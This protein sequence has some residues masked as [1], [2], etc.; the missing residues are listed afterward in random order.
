MPNYRRD[1]VLLM[2]LIQ[3]LPEI[4]VIISVS[5]E[6]LPNFLLFSNRLIIGGCIYGERLRT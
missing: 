2:V 3:V 4:R 1:L 5:L 6:V